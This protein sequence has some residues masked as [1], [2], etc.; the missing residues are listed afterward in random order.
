MKISKWIKRGALTVIAVFLLLWGCGKIFENMQNVADG[1]QNRFDYGG[2][3]EKKYAFN[4]E[5]AV[6]TFSLPVADERIKLLQFYFPEELDSKDERWP[7]VIMANGTG[8]RASKYRA[9][10]QHLASWGFI[11]AGNEDEWTWDGKSVDMTLDHL[12]RAND[13]A[14][15][16]F[17]QR[18]DT[19]RI[20]LAGHSQG[21]MAVYTSASM[22]ANSHRYKALCPLSA[23][24][25][26][27]ADSL[28]WGFLN[29]IKAPMLMLGGCGDFDTKMLC[30]PHLLRQTFDSI[31]ATPCIMG[32]IKNTDHGDMLPRGDAYMTAWMCYW[33]R[34]DK[35]AGLCFFGTD[36]E[37]LS[38]KNFQDVTRK[39]L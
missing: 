17:Y 12:L 15:S 39:E 16:R 18:I 20:G 2:K 38:N 11:V 29:D 24:A 6:D 14:N 10:F 21:G 37:I 25:S 32:R 7:V 3:L 35:E 8:I 34:D 28:G 31:A 1:Y 27:L 19:T 36:A 30:Q 23:T 4:G 13:D 26:L 9:I 33:L 5:Y 22:F